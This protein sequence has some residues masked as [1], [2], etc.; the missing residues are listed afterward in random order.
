MLILALSKY[1]YVSTAAIR[2]HLRIARLSRMMLAACFSMNAAFASGLPEKSCAEMMRPVEV[3]DAPTR[4]RALEDLARAL[5]MSVFAELM[6]SKDEQTSRPWLQG[7]SIADFSRGLDPRSNI[8]CSIRN[9]IVHIYDP[10]ALFSPVNAWNHQ[11]KEFEV[12]EVAELFL[13][14]FRSKAQS[15][16]FR[17]DDSELASGSDTG[18]IS[19]YAEKYRLKHEFLV[20]IVARDLFFREASQIPMFF[21]VQIRRPSNESPLLAWEETDRESRSG[22]LQ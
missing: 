14:R 20:N 15:E 6:Y 19:S 1:E 9:G 22:V 18:A 2:K 13:L 11:F 21:I 10:V 8:Q 4:V 12:P 7:R 3:A 16:S 5:K 17:L